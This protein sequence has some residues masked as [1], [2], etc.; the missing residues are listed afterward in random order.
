MCMHE[1]PDVD[2]HALTI[3]LLRACM[4]VQLGMHFMHPVTV[5]P[6]VELAKGMH[7]SDSTFQRTLGL[8]QRLGKTVCVSQDRPGFIMYRVLMP[9]INEVRSW[10][11]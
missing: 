8:C 5:V 9:M 10:G 11:S 3:G 4:L 7:T 2:P 6:L 1:H